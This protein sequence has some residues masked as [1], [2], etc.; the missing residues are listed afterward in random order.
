[1]SDADDKKARLEAI[2]A[3]NRAKAEAEGRAAAAVPAANAAAP[4]RNPRSKIFTVAG[5]AIFIV[6]VSGLLATTTGQ[7]LP[8]IVFGAIFGVVFGL[9]LASWPPGAGDEVTGE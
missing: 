1:M 4:A 5:I 7:Y 6:I 9:M 2:R 8:A 3:A